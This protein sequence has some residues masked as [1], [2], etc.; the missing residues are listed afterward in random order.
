MRLTSMY[1]QIQIRKRLTQQIVTQNIIEM[2]GDHSDDW[3]IIICG[4]D[5]HI[6]SLQHQHQQEKKYIHAEMLKWSMWQNLS[7]I[8][9]LI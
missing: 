9:S 6:T 5:G 2:E 8:K 1:L 4:K 7:I 3:F